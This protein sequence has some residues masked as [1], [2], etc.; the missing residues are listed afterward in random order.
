MAA[1]MAAI[2]VSNNMAVLTSRLQMIITSAAGKLASRFFVLHRGFQ[3]ADSNLDTYR[4]QD[5]W[6]SKWS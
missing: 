6:R 3:G 2:I 5:L 1:N 4:V